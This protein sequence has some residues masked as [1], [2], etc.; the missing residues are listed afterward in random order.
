MAGPESDKFEQK[1]PSAH[2]DVEPGGSL[3]GDVALHAADT[4]EPAVVGSDTEEPNSMLR[5]AKSLPTPT[6]EA[7]V[8]GLFMALELA[9][10]E[11]GT[12]TL[13]E[14]RDT[15]DKVFGSKPEGPPT[16]DFFEP[17]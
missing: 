13:D 12:Q 11:D 17:Y 7:G 5:L 15:L 1:I 3:T 6:D 14:A 4:P 2:S 9:Q 10:V 8:S 16:T